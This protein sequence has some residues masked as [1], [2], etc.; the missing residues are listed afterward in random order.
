MIGVVRNV[1][2]GLIAS[3]LSLACCF[4]YGALI[5]TGPLQPFLA[6]GVAAA[7]MTAVT[8]GCLIAWTSGFRLAIAGPDSNTA[9]RSPPRWRR[10]P[11]H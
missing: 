6:S 11:R 5:F 1:G 10:S 2:A 8:T 9:A 4:S 3:S 7:L